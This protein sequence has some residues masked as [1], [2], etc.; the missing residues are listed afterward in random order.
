[1]PR[2]NVEYLP[3]LPE[4]TGKRRETL[5]M[6]KTTLQGLLEVLDGKYGKGWRDTVRG[7]EGKAISP[8]ILV[9]IN[10]RLSRDMQHTLSD[11][12]VVVFTPGVSGG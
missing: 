11:G 9:V 10:G 3:L 5:E 4:I 6:E 2:I 12:D 7:K 8:H 1:M